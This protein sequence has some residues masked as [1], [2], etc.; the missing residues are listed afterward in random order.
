[1]GYLISRC[2]VYFR[3]MELYFFNSKRSGVFLR[4]FSVM[5]RE[6]P[7]RP[8]FLCSVHSKMIWMRLPLLFF[9]IVFLFF[10]PRGGEV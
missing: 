8:L 9:A 6:V 2:M 7:G 10:A 1:M 4:F 5:W 3:M